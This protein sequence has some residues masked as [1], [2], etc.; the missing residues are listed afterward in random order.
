MTG[1]F[2]TIDDDLNLHYEQAGNG[3]TTVLFLPGWTMST[4]VFEHQLD[5]FANSTDYRF[6]TYD[7]RAQGLSSKTEGGHYYQQHGDDL[8]AFI[9]GLGLDN[10]VLGGWSFATLATLAY[11]EQHGSDRLAGFIML[12]GPPRTAGESNQHDWVTYCYDDRDQQQAFF[13]MGRLLDREATNIEFARWMLEDKSTDNIDWVVEITNQTPDTAAALLNASA[14]F[15]DYRDSLI[16][17]HDKMP[18]LYVVRKDQEKI[19]NDWAQT[20]TPSAQV[21]AFGEHL[22]FWERAD[23][24]NK[25]LSE[26]LSRVMKAA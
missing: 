18:L 12:D 6:I 7:P 13:T 20:H 17:L 8:N 4:R 26:F 11:V 16:H 2:L 10:I 14:N 24:F 15:L 9:E 19:V 22:M 1:K 23:E 25:A 5:Y 3:E 21:A